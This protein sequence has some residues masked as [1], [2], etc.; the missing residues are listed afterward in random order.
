MG[1]VEANMGYIVTCLKMFFKR[2]NNKINRGQRDGS[3]INK[4]CCF[5]RSE[6]SSQH[7]N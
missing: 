6:F 5:R 3:G 2:I 1:Q 7:P 4:P